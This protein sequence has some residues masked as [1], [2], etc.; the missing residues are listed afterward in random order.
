MAKNSA[1]T[2]DQGKAPAFQ[3]YAAD[4]DTATRGWLP[5]EVGVYI[6][7][8]CTQW[9]TGPLPTE[10]RRLAVIVGMPVQDFEE[11]WKNT[12]SHKFEKSKTGYIN[13]RLEKVRDE[14]RQYR[15]S[16]S[17]NGRKGA[18][19]RWGKNGD[20]NGG[21]NSDPISDANSQSDG[22]PNGQT[23]GEGYGELH[24]ERYGQNIALQSSVSTLHS[25]DSRLQVS[26]LPE[27]LPRKEVSIDIEESI[28]GAG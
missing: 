28:G 12:I 17:E 4:F 24:G 8:L 15:E 10:P 25:P 2:L 16:Q 6:R 18:R 1:N 26:V 14:Q 21:A 11:I 19:K 27:P 9:I 3:F 13:K 7:L 23:Y 20:P 22:D 5:D